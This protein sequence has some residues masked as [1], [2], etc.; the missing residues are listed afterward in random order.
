MKIPAPQQTGN[1]L[2]LEQLSDYNLL[3]EVAASQFQ[4]VSQFGK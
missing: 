1:F 3:K 2:F 4:S